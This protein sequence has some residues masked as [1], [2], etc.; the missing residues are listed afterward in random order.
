MRISQ[1]AAESGVP[2]PT[3]KFYLREGLLH[4]GEL[5]SATQAQ[6]DESHVRRL[7]LVRALLGAGGLSVASARTV[8]EHIDHPPDTQHD[9]LGVA[10]QAVLRPAAEDADLSEV[11]EL[12]RSW[13]WQVDLVKDRAT[14]AALADAL[15]GLAAAGFELPEGSLDM[16]AAAMQEI[17]A[18]EVAQ[19]P[20]DS[21]E[22]AVRYVVLGTVLVEPLLLALRRLAQ[23]EESSRRF[24]TVAAPE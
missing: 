13:G 19:V 3:V 4:E 14:Q 18:V 16:Y 23:Q 9:L 11:Q 10:H 1:L 8:L 7:R 15:A 5:T 6:Y 20:T 24:G 2:L 21:A 17:A 12:L 22:A